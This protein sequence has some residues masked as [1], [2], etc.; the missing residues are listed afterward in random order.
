M[1][2]QNIL[3]DGGTYEHGETISS[4]MD[5]YGISNLD[6][7][8]VTHWDE[9]HCGGIRY[10]R[11]QGRVTN[12]YASYEGEYDTNEIKSGDMFNLGNSQL[13]CLSPSTTTYDDDNDK[14]VVLEYKT[15]SCKVLLTGDIPSTIESTLNLEDVNI[16]KVAHHG[17][18]YSTSDEFLSLTT[19]EDAVIQV[20]KHNNYGHPAPE[21]VNRLEN[22]NIKIHDTRTSGAVIVNIYKNYYEVEGYL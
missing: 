12:I 2:S 11:E 21:V 7:A 20:G 16:L 8:I 13:V 10:L 18:K 22:N 19:P 17:S 6:V 15:T 4:V 9:D 14:S 5:Y 3:I 1:D